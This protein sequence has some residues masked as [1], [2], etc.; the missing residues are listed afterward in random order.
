MRRGPNHLLADV[1]R[2]SMRRAHWVRPPQLWSV[3]AVAALI[4]RC[5]KNDEVD[6]L[7]KFAHKVYP[8]PHSAVHI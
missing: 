3:H 7:K 4:A 1:D 8:R 5:M 6:V 2:T